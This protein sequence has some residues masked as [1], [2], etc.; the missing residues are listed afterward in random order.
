MTCSR[1]TREHEIRESRRASDG[2]GVMIQVAGS[3]DVESRA[4]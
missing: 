4:A 2:C 3:T 1:T